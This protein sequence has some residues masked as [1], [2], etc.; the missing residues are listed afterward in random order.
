M[1]TLKS[2]LTTTAVAAVAVSTIQAEGLSSSLPLGK[3]LAA[4]N[5]L[6]LPLGI[7]ANVFYLEQDMEAQ[8][9]SIDVPPLPLPGGPPLQLP[10][11]LP[12]L[13]TKL[14]S[15]ATSTTAKIDAWLLPF[16]NVYGVAGYVDGETNANGFTV[17]GLPPQVAGLL[18]NSF[19]V[20]YSGPVYGGGATLAVG[21]GSYFASLDA[22]YTESDLDI[23]D[24]AIEAF[25]LTPRI[26]ING[27][28]GELEGAFYIGAQ[29]QDIDERQNG[30]VNFPIMG[31]SVPVGYD[32][33]SEAEDEWNFLLG[34]NLK[35]G[36]NWNY[37]LEA[38][39]SERKHIMAPLN[40]RF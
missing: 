37:G 16:L 11:G 1:K 39:F 3:S 15:R 18:P 13:T 23:G 19:S 9:I 12:A 22:N 38:G 21:Y 29:Y 31:Q 14:E 32:V 4:G 30:S 26:G 40:Y 20:T 2:A 25:T 27:S 34:I 7:S 35:T 33:V 10:P 24:S 17:A 5:E 36:G 6:P 8:S 28:L